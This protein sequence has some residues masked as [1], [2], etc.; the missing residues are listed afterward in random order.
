MRLNK[1]KDMEAETLAGKIIV[2]EFV[3]TEKAE[4]TNEWTDLKR[5]LMEESE[6]HKL[7]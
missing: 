5:R 3:D 2:G 7:I 4:L 6:C 1:A